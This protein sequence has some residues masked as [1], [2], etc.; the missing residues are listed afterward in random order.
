MR[1]NYEVYRES[2]N[3]SNR[4]F[5]A[6]ICTYIVQLYI[7]AG[8]RYLN[9]LQK[10][11]KFDSVQGK[12]CKIML[13]VYLHCSW[14]TQPAVS[15]FEVVFFALAAVVAARRCCDCRPPPR[16][17]CSAVN[18]A[19]GGSGRSSCGAESGKGPPD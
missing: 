10:M 11:I 1:N 15:D 4:I 16:K 9:Y 12:S 2:S 17:E 18:S 7:D 5:F 14:V 13:K 3:L 19:G 6:I 8:H